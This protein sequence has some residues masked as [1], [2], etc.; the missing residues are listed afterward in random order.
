MPPRWPP[1]IIFGTEGN[2]VLKYLK[3]RNPEDVTELFEALAG[4]VDAVSVHVGLSDEVSWRGSPHAEL[5]GD[6]MADDCGK[7]FS[8]GNA[9]V[10]SVLSTNVTGADLFADVSRRHD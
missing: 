4:S 5:W 3:R 8:D 1:R 9:T 10:A 7:L 2:L 6:N